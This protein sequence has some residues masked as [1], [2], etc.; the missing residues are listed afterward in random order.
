M[1]ARGLIGVILV[2]LCLIGKSA[3][4]GAHPHVWIDATAELS[5]NKKGQW[6]GVTITW[7]FDEFYSQASVEGF[8]G[9]GDGFPDK[10][11]MD[12]MI[13]EAVENLREWIYFTDARLG[14]TRLAWGEGAKGTASWVDERLVYRFVLPLA[15]PVDLVAQA[16][17]I[18]L[19][20][21]DPTFYIS[22]L[23]AE[24]PDAAS[25][26]G[27]PPG[28]QVT[29]FEPEGARDMT[30]D[31]AMAISEDVQPGEEGLGF[32]YAQRIGVRCE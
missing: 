22:I 31:D 13:G 20:L 2:G 27:A 29:V 1:S 7:T 3:P 8:D 9:D 24:T 4:A 11:P 23:L 6:D 26:K 15:T 18:S 14:D 25:L 16:K 10:A 12:A 5:V 28:C 32:P 30:F 19:R 21:Y 17:E